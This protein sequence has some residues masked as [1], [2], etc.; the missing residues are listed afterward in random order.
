MRH[1]EVGLWLGTSICTWPVGDLGP[2]IQQGGLQR[3]NV[4]RSLASP[5]MSKQPGLFLPGPPPSPSP[6]PPPTAPQACHPSPSPPY[7]LLLLQSLLLGALG[8]SPRQSQPPGPTPSPPFRPV[9]AETSLP[10]GAF[11]HPVKSPFPASIF[12]L[13]RLPTPQGR[14]LMAR[15]MAGHLCVAGSQVGWPGGVSQA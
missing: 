12:T 10:R 4:H 3:L 1:P 6:A 2:E 9:L 7:P 5:P 11:S 14:G 15:V 8:D 13:P